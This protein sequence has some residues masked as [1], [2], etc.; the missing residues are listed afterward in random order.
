[1]KQALAVFICTGRFGS[2]A[3]VCLRPVAVSQACFWV[4]LVRVSPRP[5]T[6]GASA[7]RRSPALPDRKWC[8]R[9][10]HR[11]AHLHGMLSTM[12]TCPCALHHGTRRA[13]AELSQSSTRQSARTRTHMHARARARTHARTRTNARARTHACTWQ[14]PQAHT[15][16]AVAWACAGILPV[17]WRCRRPLATIP[18]PCQWYR[19]PRTS[20]Q[21]CVRARVRACVRVRVRARARMEL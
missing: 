10:R 7:A 21:A 14:Q 19:S 6:E 15:A 5:Y 17:P 1:M 13:P 16:G 3:A 18:A 12:R 20:A 9:A 11:R 4:S 2:A 8:A